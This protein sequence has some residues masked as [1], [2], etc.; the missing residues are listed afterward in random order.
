MSKRL[1]LIAL[2]LCVGKG[3]VA[4]PTP[5]KYHEP[6][7][8]AGM[9]NEALPM[10]R[11]L[12]KRRA[13][14]TRSINPTQLRSADTSSGD[15]SR[16]AESIVQELERLIE[17]NKR[18]APSF[19]K[20]LLNTPQKTSSRS[21]QKNTEN[22]KK[23]KKKKEHKSKVSRDASND[24]ILGEIA[25]LSLQLNTI[26]TIV[27][28]L[29]NVMARSGITTV[30]GV[31]STNIRAGNASTQ[32]QQV[33][34][35]TDNVQGTPI[36]QADLPITISSPG[37]YFLKTDVTFNT[38]SGAAIT[39]TTDDVEV[40]L[41]KHLLDLQD[42][43]FQGILV[44]DAQ[45]VLIRNGTVA[46][47]SLFDHIATG[48]V[49]SRGYTATSMAANINIINS[50]Q[51]A[52]E[53]VVSIDGARGALV[54][55]GQSIFIDR[56]MSQGSTVGLAFFDS[57]GDILDAHVTVTSRG[58][59]VNGSRF[60]ENSTGIMLD[61]TKNIRLSECQLQ[62]CNDG[63]VG[64]DCKNTDVKSCVLSDCRRG[65]NFKGCDGISLSSCMAKDCW[66]YCYN[67]ENNVE[68]HRNRTGFNSDNTFASRNVLIS[69]CGGSLVPQS[70]APGTTQYYVYGIH[71]ASSN[72]SIRN[73]SADTTNAGP[74]ADGIFVSN[75]NY[76]LL[77]QAQFGW[78][79]TDTLLTNTQYVGSQNNSIIIQGC[80]VQH[81]GPASSGPLDENT[82]SFGAAIYLDG[83]KGLSLR[84]CVVTGTGYF[85]LFSTDC[86]GLSI[87]KC[88]CEGLS[89]KGLF[90]DETRNS[91]IKN[92]E[93]STTGTAMD[94]VSCA[95]ILVKGN[96]CINNTADGIVIN[97][98]SFN[99]LVHE[100]TLLRCQRVGLNNLSGFSSGFVAYKNT[101]GG[102]E[103]DQSNV[104]EIELNDDGGVTMSG[105]KRIDH[106]F[107]QGGP[108]GPGG[109]GGGGQFKQIQ[110]D[111]QQAL[112]IRSLKDFTQTPK[113]SLQITPTY[114]SISVT[115][116]AQTQ[117]QVIAP[118]GLGFGLM[119]LIHNNPTQLC[120]AIES[121][122][123]TRV[124]AF[125][126]GGGGSAVNFMQNFN[127]M[128]FDGHINVERDLY[129]QFPLNKAGNPITLSPRMYGLKVGQGSNVAKRAIYDVGL[130]DNDGK[131][132][133]TISHGYTSATIPESDASQH[134]GSSN[135]FPNDIGLI[136]STDLNAFQGQSPIGTWKIYMWN[137]LHDTTQTATTQAVSINQEGGSIS[138]VIPAE[139]AHGNSINVFHDSE[140]NQYFGQYD[141]GLTSSRTVVIGVGMHMELMPAS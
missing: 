90:L 66:Q 121:P 7:L 71:E 117:G 64:L 40:D 59:N 36:T 80:T 87:D 27:S 100:N 48:S 45:H 111:S 139:L 88:K 74:G 2:L 63:L 97:S 55:G 132:L 5:Y 140:R 62:G 106:N 58:C 3:L 135:L 104:Q 134:S 119:G 114:A 1:T 25:S 108:G 131:S 69:D 81:N 50:Q 28:N 85:G 75:A 73:C 65:F 11:T 8:V 33:N 128:G 47:A 57:L 52:I 110:A 4:K 109:P 17:Q 101:I 70:Q 22:K 77:P 126:G 68:G 51:V 39:V 13:R 29:T 93:L 76:S 54:S 61:K 137:A 15:Y 105:I 133:Q 37:R 79:V 56:Y 23:K 102:S 10:G 31:D 107:D 141:M 18:L 24:Q 32:S 49:M 41:N 35:G 129:P 60:I 42:S 138:G 116:N 34:E 46:N 122:S 98:G 84:D 21:N 12:R 19:S 43:G 26:Q 99:I 112:Y 78:Q 130:I 94:L 120:V 118:N 20:K 53:D 83:I 125:T 115:N 6:A 91:Q 136:H 16:E 44:T 30:R 103:K 96:E 67:V 9:H 72:T 127:F 95:N 113:Y 123:G 82:K 92:C 38:A 14:T 89:G 124:L 86:V